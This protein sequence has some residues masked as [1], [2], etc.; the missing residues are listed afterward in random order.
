M[1]TRR[2]KLII[3]SLAV[4][5]AVA[6]GYAVAQYDETGLPPLPP[7]DRIKPRSLNV[8]AARSTQEAM[9]I[10]D[11]D[12]DV[13][14]GKGADTSKNTVSRAEVATGMGTYAAKVS[15]SA[16]FGD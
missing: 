1:A 13:A 2:Q 4:I 16:A 15:A 9:Q 5:A 11:P 12:V 7:R 8:L 6:I 14:E 10:P 3:V